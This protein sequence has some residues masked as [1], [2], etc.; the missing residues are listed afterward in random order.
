[1]SSEAAALPLKQNRVVLAVDDEPDLLEMYDSYL[2]REGYQCV[3]AINGAKAIEVLN[4]RDDIFL[5]I[6]DARMPEVHGAALLG[7]V[8]I[9]RPHLEVIIVSG[10]SKLTETFAADS[11]GCVAVLAKPISRADLMKWVEEAWKR[12]VLNIGRTLGTSNH[13]DVKGDEA[14]VHANKEGI[15]SLTGVIAESN[16]IPNSFSSQSPPPLPSQEIVAT[17]T[18]VAQASVETISNDELKKYVPI[19]I[20]GYQQIKAANVNCFLLNNGQMIAAGQLCDYDANKAQ[21][22]ESKGIK[23]FWILATDLSLYQ[24]LVVKESPSVTIRNGLADEKKG[25]FLRH[26]VMVASE[27]LCRSGVSEECVISAS[28]IFTECLEPFAKTSTNL[29]AFRLVEDSGNF[30]VDHSATTALFCCLLTRIMGWSS[31]KNITILCLGGYLHDIGLLEIP[32]EIRTKPLVLLSDEDAKLYKKHPILGAKK[33]KGMEGIPEEVIKIVAQHHE[34]GGNQGYPK[35][36]PRNQVFPMAK[37][38]TLVDAF[39]ES[40]FMHNKKKGN[41]SPI[42]ILETV[43]AN[44]DYVGLDQAAM[45][46]MRIAL[47]ESDLVK[48]QRQYAKQMGGGRA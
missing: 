22:L 29:N 14:K 44:P 25:Y 13:A 1:M 9:N 45:V 19:S 28:K 21:M 32:E 41:V 40:V 11:L 18:A 16:T 8:K 17:P 47:K 27:N 7:W 20:R 48:A 42:D 46:A 38:V 4:A 5:V 15:V 3:V 36:L 33:L 34:T 12:S 26:A 2:T 23:Q 39:T 37:A 43:L 24:S 35:G 30:L 10:F 6:T 31:S